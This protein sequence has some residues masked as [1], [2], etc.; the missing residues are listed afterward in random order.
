MTYNGW[1]NWETWITRCWYDDLDGM[2]ADAIEELVRMDV[3]TK[4]THGLAHDFLEISL[5]LVNWQEIADAFEEAK[6]D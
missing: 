4:E 2:D 6:D 5:G 3:E 1:T